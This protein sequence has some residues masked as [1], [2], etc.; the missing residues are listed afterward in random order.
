MEL[1]WAFDG[2]HERRVQDA[3][4]A[5]HRAKQLVQQEDNVL[6]ELDRHRCQ[7]DADVRTCNT[8]AGRIEHLQDSKDVLEASMQHEKQLLLRIQV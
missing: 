2:K 1:R 8:L 3:E 7:R 4:D 5:V 6:Q